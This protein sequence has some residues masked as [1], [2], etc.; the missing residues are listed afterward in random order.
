ML[1]LAWAIAFAA[2]GRAGG[3][4]EA[5]GP[6]AV[7][8]PFQL[9]DN[10]IFVPVTVEGRGPYQFIFDT[11]GRNVLDLG[12]A[13]ELKLALEGADAAEGAGASAQQAWQA[14][15]GETTLGAVRMREQDF[16]VTSL[17][18]I[19]RAIGFRRFDGVVGAELLS[20][21][22]IDID[23]AQQ[24]LTFNDAATWT[25]DAALGPGLPLDFVGDIPTI[26]GAVDGIKGR[27][28]ID[29]GDRSSLTLFGPFVERHKLRVKYP[30]K[31][32]VVTGWGIGGPIPADVT[33]VGV[34]QFAG[35]TVG[36][37]VARMPL[38]KSGGFASTDAA[39]SIGTGVLKRF[40]AVFDYRHKRMF[41]A[42]NPG[43]GAVDPADRSGMWLSLADDGFVVSSIVSG[44]P[45]DQS[46]IKVGDVVTAVNGAAAEQV[47]LVELRERLKSDPAGS[48]VRFAVRRGQAQRSADVTLR[49][50]IQ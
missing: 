36:A 23:Y 32:Q 5:T 41:L 11:G 24:R 37:V 50:L 17:E 21:F 18:P 28:L 6:G 29:T 4:I 9:I 22:V 26:A 39:G 27:F 13:R 43:P 34:L 49:D 45:A 46:G 15:V 30:R 33:R 40:R 19:R 47:F 25:P 12:V 3:Q 38:L 8:L 7:T 35:H 48:V 20:R 14:H 1:A 42:A 31:V 44:G 10:R 16:V 2:T